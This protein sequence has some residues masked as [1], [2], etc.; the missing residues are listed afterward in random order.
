MDAVSSAALRWDSYT[1]T[2]RTLLVG[3]VVLLFGAVLDTITTWMLTTHPGV[4][5]GNPVMQAAMDYGNVW[6]LIAAKVIALGVSGP[7]LWMS[8]Q[9]ARQRR[10]L[11]FSVI[12]G[13]IWGFAGVWNLLL[14]TSIP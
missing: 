1:P 6:G 2:R 3:L 5:E 13:S 14:V 12:F 9:S 11:L 4:V 8:K 7:F 10:A